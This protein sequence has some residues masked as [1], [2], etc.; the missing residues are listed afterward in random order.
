MTDMYN[1]QQDI[2]K[3]Y[4]GVGVDNFR[5]LGG[6]ELTCGRT[7]RSDMILR[8]GELWNL[9]AENKEAL[10]K[11]KID[12][13]FDLRSP[14]E[15]EYKPDYVPSG[16]EYRNVP[17]V[18]TRKK[19][20]VKPDSVVKMIPVWLPSS[21]SRGAFRAKF[22]NLYRKFPFKNSAYAQIFKAMDDGKKILF[23]C[24]AGKD[25]TGV[26]SMLILMALGAD[27]D[28]VKQDYMLSNLY[29]VESGARFLEQFK[30]YKH[31]GKYGK[32]LPMTNNVEMCYFNASY[33][34]IIRKYGT[35]KNF[36]LKQYGI[37]EARIS[38]WLQEYTE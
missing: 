17:A 14:D 2:G 32:I 13:I 5:D 28:T 18:R 3:K 24:T 11:L 16:T 23:H 12:F 27:M 21:V 10:D 7:I 29:R 9:S 22:K 35:V 31:Y 4:V 33:N 26:A 38:K 37:D 25:R 15:V 6:I 1:K 36:L 8:S 20:A 34:K 30:G 19:M